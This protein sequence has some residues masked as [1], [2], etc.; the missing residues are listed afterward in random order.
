MELLSSE[1][2]EIRDLVDVC[3]GTVG[4]VGVSMLLILQFRCGFRWT[5]SG[6][7]DAPRW[8]CN[9]GWLVNSPPEQ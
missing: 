8:S 3:V 4:F 7:L 6:G 5:E 2:G 9:V 1:R